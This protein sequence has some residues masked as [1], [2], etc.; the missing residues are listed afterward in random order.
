MR[1]GNKIVLV[2][3]CFFAF[4]EVVGLQNAKF[5]LPNWTGY[6]LT[7]RENHLCFIFLFFYSRGCGGNVGCP[8][9]PFGAAAVYFFLVPLGVLEVPIRFIHV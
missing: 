7:F 4:C 3:D 9:V 8:N 1:I 5:R 2:P 6:P